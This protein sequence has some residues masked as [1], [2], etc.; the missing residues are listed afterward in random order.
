MREELRRVDDERYQALDLKIT[1]V[2]RD[3]GAIRDMLIS[4]P[5]AS[6]MGR[7][8]IRRS[9]EN[10]TDILDLREDFE[11]HLRDEY[12]PIRDWWVQTK[13]QWKL[14]Q[15]AALVLASIGAFF[16]ILAYWGVRP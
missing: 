7:A 1:N 14:I 2:A 8:L 12:A 6:P 11:T 16:G 9:E 4:E 15:G 13:G 5:E 3:V 10:R